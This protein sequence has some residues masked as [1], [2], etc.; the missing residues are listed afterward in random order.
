M[1]TTL[2]NT[3]IIAAAVAII[4]LV[5][6]II[7]FALGGMQVVNVSADGISLEKQGEGVIKID[8]SF[9]KDTINSIQGNFDLRD[10]ELKTGTVGSEINVF[11]KGVG[12]SFNVENVNGVLTF[13]DNKSTLFNFNL[14]GS[15]GNGQ[16][17]KLIIT[18]PVGTELN[19]V[20]IKS[21]SGDISI[22]DLKA[23]G[24]TINS[25]LGDVKF[26]NVTISK[27]STDISSGNLKLINTNFKS[28]KFDL[29][30]GD[31][32]ASGYNGE[33]ITGRLSSGDIKLEG[34]LTGPV[35]ITSDLGDLTFNISG[36]E[37]M[38]S[39]DIKTDLGDVQ[40]NGQKSGSSLMKI[41]ENKPLFKVNSSFGDVRINTK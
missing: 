21:S 9:D 34:I 27:F 8:E 24:M 3:M 22:S 1:N 17:K 41:Y 29:D 35:D 5:I 33:E 12:R 13:T 28:M 39:Y 36:N 26:D 30:L 25:D 2:K 31:I 18:Y 4:G 38:F 6:A 16:F 11:S 15:Y 20:S 32:N 14:F 37:N 19:D 40:L 7:G 10:I 23:D